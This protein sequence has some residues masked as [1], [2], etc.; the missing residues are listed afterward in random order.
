MENNIISSKHIGDRYG[1][2]QIGDR[3]TYSKYEM[4]DLHHQ[5]PQDWQWCYNDDFFSK[6]N[7]SQEPKESINELYKKRAEQLRNDYD[8]LVMYYSGGFDS[9]NMLHAFLDNNIMVDEIC[10][11]YSRFDRIS[12]QYEELENFTWN[13]LKQIQSKYPNLKIRRLDY[14]DYFLKWDSMLSSLG[15]GKDLLYMFGSALSLNHLM[16]DL[17]YRSTD[18]WQKILKQGKRLAWMHGVDKPQLRYLDGKWIFN[19]HDALV[20]TNITPMRQM[21]DDGT[22]GTY[23]F[24]YWAPTEECARILIKQCHLIKQKYD[25]QASIDFSKI[26]NSKPFKEGYGWELDKMSYDFSNTIYPRNFIGNETFYTKKNT[27]FVWGNR[28]QW[29]FNS[30]NEAAQRHWNIYLSI[31]DKKHLQPWYNDGQSIDSS[32]RN[33]LS[34]DYVI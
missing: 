17:L 23:E 14:A 4:I 26:S 10:V 34:R 24:F 31:Q 32:F 12:N 5:S 13:K 1:Y 28:D 25:Q 2:Y 19:F 3:R 20:Q 21:I 16:T 18:D 11:F 22:I 33:C 29:F 8:Y 9:S 27:Q 7:W 30:N 15:L 6:Y